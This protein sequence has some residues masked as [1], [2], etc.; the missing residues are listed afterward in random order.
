MY[1][2]DKEQELLELVSGGS[3]DAFRLLFD[4]YYPKV[5][6]FMRGILPSEEDASDLA[7]ELFI[8]VW[9]MR[10]ALP[11][12][13]S[14]NSYL[15]R[16]SLNMS[17]NFVRRNR[18]SFAD[19]LSDIPYDPMLEEALDM[20]AKEALVASVIRGMPRK[21][22]RVFVLSRMEHRSNEEISRLLNI[23]KKTVENHLNLA[24]RELRTA[25]P[26]SAFFLLWLSQ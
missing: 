17:I 13:V 3:R 15:Y 2:K 14:F 10:S 8:K 21:R 5:F 19:L 25:L 11:D 12:I 26:M 1:S 4:A 9:L 16:M 23:S 7:Q 18:P 22:R 6:G 20:K 24:L